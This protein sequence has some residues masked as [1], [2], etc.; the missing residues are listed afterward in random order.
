MPRKTIPSHR[1]TRDPKHLSKTIFVPVR[2]HLWSEVGLESFRKCWDVLLDYYAEPFVDDTGARQA[3][4]LEYV[5]IGWYC[6]LQR[7][8]WKNEA[9]TLREVEAKYGTHRETFTSYIDRLEDAELLDREKCVDL[10]GQPVDLLLRTPY[11]PATFLQERAR[12]SDRINA[13]DGENLIGFTALNRKQMGGSKAKDYPGRFLNMKERMARIRAQQNDANLKKMQMVVD[14]VIYTNTGRNEGPTEAEFV[15]QIKRT[16]KAW[17][18]FYDD[19]LL[20]DAIGQ[21]RQGG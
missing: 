3:P 12:L 19:K 7:M 16:C 17:G 10:R 5:H 4:I 18:V 8:F 1:P 13:K 20:R 2:S 11:P 21:F 14:H 9:F 15:D 6:K